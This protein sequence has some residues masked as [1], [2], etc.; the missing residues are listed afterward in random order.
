MNL[1][2]VVPSRGRPRNI[3]AL[4]DAWTAT[5]ATADLIVAVDDDDPT[6]GEYFDVVASH[7]RFDLVVGPRLGMVGSL[8]KVAVAHCEMYDAV[9]FMG[10][11]H[12]PRTAQ[13]DQRVCEALAE[14][15]TGIVYGDDLL[16]GERLPTAAF[17]TSDIIRTL[18][19]MSPPG[20]RHLYVDNAWRSLGCALEALR[21]LPDVVIEHMH[22]VAGKAESDA[23]YEA[24]N[25]SEVWQ[26]DKAEYRR[27]LSDDCENDAEHVRQAIAARV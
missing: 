17:M 12:L 18:G 27:W 4:A 10:D 24:V 11:D 9:G 1:L 26:L 5:Q 2:V 13:W 20:L 22:P 19:W 14:I 3:A 21:Y 7:P 6:C 23:G 8:N 15:G 25:A 16:Q